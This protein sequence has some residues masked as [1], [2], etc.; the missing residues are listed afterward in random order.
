MLVGV[1]VCSGSYTQTASA[2]FDHISLTTYPLNSLS[3]DFRTSWVG[4]TYNNFTN[5]YVSASIDSLYVAPDGTC[6]TNSYY[7]EG[8]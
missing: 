3:R 7:D 2:V 4:N 6:Y 5:G 1:A 8:G